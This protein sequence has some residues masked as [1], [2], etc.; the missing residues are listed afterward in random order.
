MVEAP[1][2]LTRSLLDNLTKPGDEVPSGGSRSRRDVPPG[3]Q[4]LRRLRGSIAE[5]GRGGLRAAFAGGTAAG[6]VL[7]LAAVIAH[8]AGVWPFG[9]ARHEAEPPAP[10]APVVPPEPSDSAPV[11][12]SPGDSPPRKESPSPD[13]PSKSPGKPS[14][15][16]SRP[17]QPS[18]SPEP[19]YRG[20]GGA[21]AGPQ[22]GDRGCRAS[23]QV[24]SQWEHF[25]ATIRVINT[26][27]ATIHGWTVGW[28]WPGDQKV[29]D[30]WNAG[31]RQ[32]GRNITAANDDTHGLVT[33]TGET[34]FGFE[35]T[36]SGTPAPLLSCWAE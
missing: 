33:A 4:A 21:G 27:G 35:A 8:Q 22:R 10:R 14:G 16:A 11:K 17:A 13:R 31:F 7:V 23:W 19:T 32:S 28:T 18:R 15:S 36:G 5:G 34:T 30:S 9:V 26:S 24:D 20:G 1:V 25:T 3:W 12:P 6:L 2:T 29:V